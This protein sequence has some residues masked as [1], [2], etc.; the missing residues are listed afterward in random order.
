MRKKVA[1]QAKQSDVV[2]VRSSYGFDETIKRLED[3]IAVREL[4]IFARIDHAANAAAVGLDMAPE[5]VLVFGG[6]G[7]GTP[8]MVKAPG[9]ALDL[10]LRLLVRQDPDGVMVSYHDPVAVLAAYGLPAGDAAPLA[11]VSSMAQSVSG[12]LDETC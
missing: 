4:Q 3:E 6:A 10:P 8:L 5:T 11:G 9:L 7:G 1:D 2:E 12:A